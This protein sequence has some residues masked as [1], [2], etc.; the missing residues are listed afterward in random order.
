MSLAISY[1]RNILRG[2]FLALAAALALSAC[3]DPATQLVIDKARVE[4]GIPGLSVAVI[5]SER[6]SIH[7]SGVRRLGSQQPVGRNDLFYVGSE[8]KAMLATVIARKVEAGDLRWDLTVREAFPLLTSHGEFGEVTLATLLQHRSGL[9][10]FETAEELAEVPEL[11]GTPDRQ[12]LQFVEWILPREAS[13]I[14]GQSYLYSNAGYIVAT[15]ML[16]SATGQSYESLMRGLL[17]DPLGI[18]PA[19]ALP[20]AGK[21]NQPWG[22]TVIHGTLTPVDPEDPN[23]ILPP[24]THPAGNLSLTTLDFAKFVQTHLRGLRGKSALLQRQTF[25][26]LHTPVGDY[27]CGWLVFD[28]RGMRASAH[29]GSNDSFYAFMILEP[30]ADAAAVVVANASSPQIDAAVVRLGLAVLPRRNVQ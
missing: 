13:G 9:P 11:T 17:F 12:R 15:A 7:T 8:A 14:P 21:R 25:E 3:D 29:S 26:V 16:E 23:G 1:S 18:R 5:T 30:E 2:C 20:A 28:D 4:A 19:Y 10:A 6:I 27:A 24:W 22:H